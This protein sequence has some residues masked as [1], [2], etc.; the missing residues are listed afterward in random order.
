MSWIDAAR[1]GFTSISSAHSDE[2]LSVGGQRC[3]GDWST[4][5]PVST[6]DAVPALITE[7]ERLERLCQELSNEEF[8]AIDTEFHTERTYWPALALIQLAWGNRIALVDPLA[9]DPAPLRH[10]FEGPGTAI[11]HAAGQDLDILQTACGAAPAR[12]FDT[13]VAAGF[14]GMSSPSLGRLVDH[15][16]GISLAKADQ[17][18]DW[19]QRPLPASQLAYAASDVE[20]L[21]ALRS[22]MVDRLEQRGR[23]EWALEECTLI[24][25]GQR[26]TVVPEQAWWKVGD[27]RRLTGRARGVAQEVT[28]WREQR[29]AEVDRPRRS[30]LSDL[31]VLTIAQRP[32]NTRQ[33]LEKLRGVDARSLAKGGAAEILEAVERGTALS[34]DELRLPP[35]A[36]ESKASQVAVAMCGGLVRQIA[37]QLEFDQSLLATRLDIALLVVGEPS[38]LDQ[39][40]RRDLAGTPIRRLLSGEVAAAF[41]ENGQLILEARSHMPD[42]SGPAT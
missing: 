23:L 4:F 14:L 22:V 36:A 33:Q 11:A 26:R 28:A 5:Q 34:L 19:L 31:A 20:H 41:D 30:V 40:W 25:P 12:V 37:E 18:S 6:I 15:V 8:Y 10:V 3:I 16:L 1:V 32:P 29:A 13:Q 7:T 21:Q 27:M 42:G 17:L 9:V 24:L 38:R 2:L 35:D 39:G